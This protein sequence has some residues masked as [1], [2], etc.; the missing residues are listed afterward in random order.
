MIAVRVGH[1]A[2]A[3]APSLSWPDRAAA[4]NIISHAK[5]HNLSSEQKLRQAG[6]APNFDFSELHRPG[7]AD[8]EAAS[9]RVEK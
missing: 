5:M 7:P 3:L 1:A 8:L 6:F 2:H 9:G 4:M